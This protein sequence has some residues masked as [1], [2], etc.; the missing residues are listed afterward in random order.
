[1]NSLTVQNFKLCEN[2]HFNSHLSWAL[3]K[4]QICK[5][6][7]YSSCKTTDFDGNFNQT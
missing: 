7:V 1:M 6:T 4:V 5:T 3:L 2:T